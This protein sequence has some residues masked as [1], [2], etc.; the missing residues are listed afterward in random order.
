MILNVL[1]TYRQPN[2]EVGSVPALYEGLNMLPLPLPTDNVYQDLRGT[3][4]GE[5]SNTV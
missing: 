3:S 4:V 1:Y 5:Q 2:D